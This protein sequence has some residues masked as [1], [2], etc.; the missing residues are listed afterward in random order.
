MVLPKV[1]Q[2][3]LF[4]DVMVV[5]FTAQRKRQEDASLQEAHFNSMYHEVLDGIAGTNE[6]VAEVQE[7]LQHADKL[8]KQKQHDLYSS[9]S[10]QVFDKIQ[11]RRA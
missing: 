6:V 4:T 8:H 9:W 5:I 11:V 7:V 2:T 1:Q 3:T 10:T